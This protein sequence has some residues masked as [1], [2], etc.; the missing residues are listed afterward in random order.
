MTTTPE[1]TLDRSDV[2]AGVAAA[3]TA[4]LNS[5]SVQVSEQ[6]RLMDD[7]GLDST[8]VLELL[9]NLE[10]QLTVTIDSDT[11]EHRHFE[12]VGTLADYIL[13]QSG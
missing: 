13:E 10:D 2:V 8:N 4:V 6:T 12:T 5:D 9:M 1:A 7:L 11:L 3:V